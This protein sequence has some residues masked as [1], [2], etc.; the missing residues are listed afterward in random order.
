MLN[1]AKT[2]RPCTRGLEPYERWLVRRIVDSLAS[3]DRRVRREGIG[4]T[5]DLF[6]ITR[7]I[8]AVFGIPKTGMNRLPLP[9]PVGTTFFNQRTNRRVFDGLGGWLNADLTWHKENRPLLS[10]D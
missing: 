4:E 10:R 9:S 5:V 6:Q 1:A 8:F 3:H 2:P 7:S